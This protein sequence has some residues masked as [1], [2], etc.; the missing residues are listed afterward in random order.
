MSYQLLTKNGHNMFDV[1]SLV[2]KAIRRQDLEYACYAAREMMYKY[3]SYLWKRLLVVTAEDCF[4]LVT[5]PI[6]ILKQRDDECSNLYETKHISQAINL[7]VNTRKSRDADFFACN[8]LNS[9]FKQ[10]VCPE[11]EGYL[12]TRHG[13]DLKEMA[14]LLRELIL[15]VDGDKCGYVANEIRNWYLGLFWFVV[16]NVAKE[17]GYPSVIREIEVLCY[18][19]MSKP[20]KDTTFIYAAKALTILMRVAE[21]GNADFYQMFDVH[22]YV[23]IASFD[24]MRVIPMYTY[25]CHT[26]RGRKMGLTDA[27]F[28]VSEQAALKPLELGWYDERD[29][30]RDQE[31]V[32]N[33]YGN[34][35]NTPK[36]PKEILDGVNAGIFPTSLFD[37][38]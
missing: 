15:S 5:R 7:L 6:F 30:G 27:D 16:N 26:I 32:K 23:D 33:G 1:S 3:R 31:C 34:D 11:G 17:L 9:K 36:M 25:D 2:Q 24:K 12:V 22:E 35:F 8:L 37:M 10:D 4:D 20:V 19:D 29:W 21:R 13:H 38:L 18:L 28:I 14:S